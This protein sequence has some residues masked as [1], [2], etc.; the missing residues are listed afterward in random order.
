[1]YTSKRSN[2]GSPTFINNENIHR[3][4][5]SK[6]GKNVARGIVREKRHYYFVPDFFGGVIGSAS[7]NVKV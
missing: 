6:Y 5:W 2:I 1:M 7:R 4:V 3:A